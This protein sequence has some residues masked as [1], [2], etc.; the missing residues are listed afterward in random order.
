MTLPDGTL[1]K[2]N[3]IRQGDIVSGAFDGTN[4]AG[5][6]A[7]N[8]SA[9]TAAGDPIGDARARFLVFE[10][11]LELDNAAADPTLLASLSAMTSSLGGRSLAPEELPALIE[12]FA[13]QP[14]EMEIETQEKLTPWDTWPFFLL[15]IATISGEWYLRKRWG[16]V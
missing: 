1:S 7:I 11:D 12:E 16:L 4:L 6:Y 9:D 14:Q 10:Q 3:L 5:D 8:I 2:V 13:S 15:F